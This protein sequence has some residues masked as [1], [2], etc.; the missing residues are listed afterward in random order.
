[1]VLDMGS[2][3]SER[4]NVQDKGPTTYT[5]GVVNNGTAVFSLWPTIVFCVLVVPYESY[6]VHIAVLL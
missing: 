3:F 2:K 1:M 6:N 5:Y 4:N